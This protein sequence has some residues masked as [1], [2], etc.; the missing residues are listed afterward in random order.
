MT[1]ES[2]ISGFDRISPHSSQNSWGVLEFRNRGQARKKQEAVCSLCV[3][4]AVQ[5]DLSRLSQ[6]S[7]VSYSSQVPM[8]CRRCGVHIEPVTMAA[9]EEPLQVCPGVDRARGVPTDAPP[10]ARALSLRHI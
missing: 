7:C 1:C 3:H 5:M 9:V 6:S 4:P 2:A 10:P 8:Q